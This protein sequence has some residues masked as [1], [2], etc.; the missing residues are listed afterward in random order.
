MWKITIKNLAANKARLSLTGLAI[1]LGV[2]FVVASLVISFIVVPSMGSE[3]ASAISAMC[4]DYR[5]WFFA[6][7]FVCIGLETRVKDLVT[8]GGGKPA[9][10]YW[11]AQLMNAF[12]TLGIVWLLWS[13]RFFTPPILPD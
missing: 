8:V 2:G 11:I 12:W 7:C 3:Q 4:K 5:T 1:V 6:L 9:A 10:A 13:G